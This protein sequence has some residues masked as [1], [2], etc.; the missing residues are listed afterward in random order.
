MCVHLICRIKN[1]IIIC[2]NHTI[3]HNYN[4]IKY[5]GLT[6]ALY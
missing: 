2:V 3:K 4:D 1:Q 6:L 5:H